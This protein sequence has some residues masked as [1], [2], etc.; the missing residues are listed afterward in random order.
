MPA[1]PIVHKLFPLYHLYN[2]PVCFS[3][4]A[5]KAR[6]LRGIKRITKL[7][8]LCERKHGLNDEWSEDRTVYDKMICGLFTKKDLYEKHKQKVAQIL[9]KK[10]NSKSLDKEKED[11]IRAV[12]MMAKM[13]GPLPSL[14]FG[15]R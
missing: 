11:L 8:K 14:H 15:G 9:A 7:H 4:L 6:A 1:Y 3:V 10:K 13:A 2:I 12:N 5:I